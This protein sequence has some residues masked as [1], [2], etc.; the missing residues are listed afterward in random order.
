[1]NTLKGVVHYR[2]DAHAEGAFYYDANGN[3]S[4]QDPKKKLSEDTWSFA[5]ENTLHATRYFDFVTGVSYDIDE[6]LRAD[7]NSDPLPE[8]NAWNW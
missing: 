3:F 6:V 1:M 5:A 2:L 8:K 7:G 4:G